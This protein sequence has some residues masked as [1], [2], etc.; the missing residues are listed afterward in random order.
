MAAGDYSAGAGPAGHDAVAAVSRPREVTPP[1]AL[2]WDAGTKDYL[3]DSDGRFYSIHPV[4]QRVALKLS[5]IVGTHGSA[6]TFGHGLRN[7]KFA[8]AATVRAEVEDIVRTALAAELAADEISI[9]SI[10]I[11]NPTPYALLVAVNYTNLVTARRESALAR[12]GS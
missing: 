9:E 3:K 5:H 8:A 4:D 11:E 7:V 1:V 12:V 6:S 10:E 2:K